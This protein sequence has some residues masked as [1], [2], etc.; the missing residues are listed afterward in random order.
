MQA[1]GCQPGGGQSVVVDFGENLSGVVRIN[2]VGNRGDTVQLQHA[3]VLMHEPY[4]PANGS[5]YTGNLRTALALDTYTLNGTA[6]GETYQ[7]SFT[8]G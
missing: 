2:V 4:G 3:E 8:C 5:V 7:P 1:S 6:G